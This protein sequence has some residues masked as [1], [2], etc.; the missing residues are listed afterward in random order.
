MVMTTSWMASICVGPRFSFWATS[1]LATA[2]APW[3]WS[4]IWFR[5]VRWALVTSLVEGRGGLLLE[6]GHPR[7]HRFHHHLAIDVAAV[8]LLGLLGL[9]TDRLHHLPPTLVPRVREFLELRLL[10]V[11]QLQLRLHGLV[12]DDRHRLELVPARPAAPESPTAPEAATPAPRPAAPRPLGP[13]ERRRARE[14][15]EEPQARES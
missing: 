14:Q 11:R 9:L 4:E 2:S 15:G 6:G 10:L 12:I 13:N 8:F 7:L 3:A 5:R 1:G